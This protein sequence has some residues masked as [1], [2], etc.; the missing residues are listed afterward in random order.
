MR[1]G[2]FYITFANILYY[3]DHEIKLSLWIH[4]S[5]S[6]NKCIHPIKNLTMA[7]QEFKF[8]TCLKALLK[9]LFPTIEIGKGES[10]YSLISH[11]RKLKQQL[12]QRLENHSYPETSELIHS[13]KKQKA[14]EDNSFSVSTFQEESASQKTEE[15][16]KY[17][18]LKKVKSLLSLL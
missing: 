14:Q 8:Y 3:P 17:S 11:V 10:Y 12:F 15:E 13:L 9:R 5:L 4:P 7:Q 1:F 18:P 2:F 16:E 6:T